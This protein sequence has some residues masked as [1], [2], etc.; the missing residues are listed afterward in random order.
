MTY[1]G[2]YS[3]ATL[4]YEPSESR[5]LEKVLTPGCV[6]GIDDVE[7]GTDC[8]PMGSILDVVKRNSPNFLKLIKRANLLN[9]YNSSQQKHTLFLP[10]FMDSLNK[11]VDPNTAFKICKFSTT[12]GD[13][14]TDM[15]ASS[16]NFVIYSLL[17]SENLNIQNNLGVTTIENKI[18]LHGNITCTNGMIQF[19]D[20]MLIPRT[21][22]Y[23]FSCFE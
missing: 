1:V 10:F 12:P 14:T 11:Y 18:L 21:H 2:P 9:L 19:I 3:K 22:H 17:P 5:V 8:G 15:L 13:V 7:R 20:S 23:N 16:P 4:M 6:F